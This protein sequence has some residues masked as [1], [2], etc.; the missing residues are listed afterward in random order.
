MTDDKTQ[1]QKVPSGPPRGPGGPSVPHSA[2][3]PDPGPLPDP[4]QPSRRSTSGGRPGWLGIGLAAALVLGLGATLGLLSGSGCGNRAGMTCQQ[5]SD[6]SS[7]LLCNKP[8]TAG[9]QG[10]G[11][12]EPGLHGLGEVCVFSGECDPALICSTEL[13]QPS[14]DGW[15]GVCQARQPVADAAMAPDLSVRPDLAVPPDQASLDGGT[16]L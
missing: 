2:R 10:Y 15:H 1:A 12:C 6:C 4:A 13:G 7:G 5:Q 3:R 14:E 8:P 16:D 11:I 9:P